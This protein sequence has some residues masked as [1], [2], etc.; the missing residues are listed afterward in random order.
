MSYSSCVWYLLQGLEVIE[1]FLL[2]FYIIHYK[3]TKIFYLW[4][5]CALCI[6]MK[7]VL[8]LG[9]LS[10]IVINISY[11]NG[12]IGIWKGIYASHVVAYPFFIQ[13]KLHLASFVKCGYLLHCWVTNSVMVRNFLWLG[14]D[15]NRLN[16]TRNQSISICKRN[17]CR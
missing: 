1:S 17:K 11:R 2:H 14:V 6:C 7:I 10:W 3:N 4:R 16:D 5:V 13:D 15:H 9:F 8:A 12:C